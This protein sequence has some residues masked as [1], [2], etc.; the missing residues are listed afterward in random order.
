MADHWAHHRLLW[1]VRA[2]VGLLVWPAYP[3]A[4][5]LIL[6]VIVALQSSI[7]HEV[8]HGH[9]TRSALANEVLVFLPIGLVWPFRR[10]KS[11]HLRHHADER[12]DRSV[13]RSGKLLP[14]AVAA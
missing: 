11:I 6:G 8:L 12:A 13:R 1:G 7:M 2:A 5:L 9:P 3:I 14:G 10:F 4:A